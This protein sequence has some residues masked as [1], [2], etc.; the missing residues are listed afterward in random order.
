MVKTSGIDNKIFLS[1][2]MIWN[3]CH[4]LISSQ[5]F[6]DNFELNIILKSVSVS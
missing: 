1:V 3:V 4:T 2:C 5:L 6:I